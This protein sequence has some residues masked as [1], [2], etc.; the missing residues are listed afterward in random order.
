MAAA[1][2]AVA[3]DGCE[4]W[5]IELA[6]I[7]SPT[8]V[9]RAVADALAVAQRPGHALIPSI[10]AALRSRRALLVL[11]NCEHVLDGAAELVAALVTGCRQVRV[12]AT[13]RERLAVAGEQV[14][15]VEPLDPA[16]GAELFHARALAADRTYDATAHHRDVEQICRRLD[17]IPLAIELAAA[18][19]ISHRPADLV[20]RLD[21]RLRVTGDRRTGAARHRTLRAAIQW[22][23]DLLTP[24]EQTLFQRLSVFHAPFDLGAAAAVAQGSTVDDVLGHLVERS[25]VTSPLDLWAGAFGCW[26]RCASLPPSSAGH[27]ETR[28]RRQRHAR[29]CLGQV[30][31]STGSSGT[32][33][34]EGVAWL[35]ELWPNLRAAVG[36]ASRP[37][38][39]ALADA[40]VRPVAT[41]SARC[42]H[43]RNR[44]LGGGAPGHDS[45]RGPDLRAFWLVWVAGAPNPDWNPA[46]Y[47]RCGRRPRRAGPGVQPV[48]HAYVIRRR[49]G[50]MGYLPQA[51]AELRGQDE[52]YLAAALG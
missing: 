48:R 23:Y 7:T 19:T 14:L 39:L 47:E 34:G 22:S 8:D 17:G 32:G 33:E 36:W 41:A 12:L 52:E 25:M 27:G 5:L 2:A 43:G 13:A 46:G 37:A 3:T 40:L 24:A 1:R 29:W 28:Y 45:G 26:R 35:G 21:D 15:V 10:V 51:V 50:A 30:T 16:A 49:R 6:E 42:G 31:E 18:R 20:A 38:I 9:A 11:D 44:R 4:G